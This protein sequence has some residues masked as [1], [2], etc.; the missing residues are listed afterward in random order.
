VILFGY[1]AGAFTGGAAQRSARKILLADKGT[2]FLVRSAICRSP[3]QSA[4]AARWT[5]AGNAA[6]TEDTFESSFS[7]SSAQDMADLLEYIST[8]DAV[9]CVAPT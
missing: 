7:S 3:L 5:N 4:S 9:T 8:A 1:R 2:L 6:R